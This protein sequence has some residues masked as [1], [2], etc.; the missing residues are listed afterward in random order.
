MRS[1]I[2]Y[3]IKFP[4][5]V[6]IM[7]LSII[8]FGVFGFLGMKSSYFPLNDSKTIRIAI[9]YLGASPQ[10]IEE[11]IVLKIEDNLKGLVGIDRVT[12]IS[13]ENSGVITVEIEK[14]QDIDIML[15][16]VKNAVDR[17]P[18]FPT[19][20]EPVVVNKI[21]S[22][23]ETIS[24]T[25]SG[26]NISLKA[27]KDI[28]RNIENELRSMDGISQINITGYPDEEIEIAVREKDLLAYNLTFG[29]VARA[30]SRENILATGGNIKTDIEEYLIR[31]NSKSY[32]AKELDYIIVRADQN[33]NVIRLKD[34]A[35]VK[36]R[37]AESPNATF[38]NGELAVNI[39]ISN[40]NDED[41]LS[42]ASTIKSFISD[43]N[44]R[45]NNI[46]LNVVSDQSIPLNQRTQL[47]AENAMIGIVL[48]LFFLSLFLNTRLAF[49]VAAG[50]PIAFF[51]MFIFASSLGV[52]INILSL[53]GMIIV[54]GILV[55]DG[56]VIAENIYHHY[57]KGKSR[58]QAAIDGTMEVI[59][60]IVSAI[61]TT[62]LAFSTFL[63]LDGRIGDFFGEVSVVVI[64]T[65]SISLI[66]V[67]IIL[68]AHMAHSKALGIHDPNEEKKGLDKVFS[69]LRSFNKIGD[70]IISFLRDKLYSKVLHFTLE[71]KFLS[72]AIWLV[73]L[74]L[75]IGSIGGGIIRTTF[76]PTVA[77]DRVSIGLKMPEGTTIAVTDSILSLIEA[78]T[79]LINNDFTS[80]QTENRKVV[81]N[82]IKNLGPGTANGSLDVNLLPGELRDAPSA[83]IANAIRAAVGPV[84]G[85]E[86]LTFGSGGNFGGR[87]ISVSL[88]GNNIKELKA[89]KEELKANMLNNAL[90]ADITDNDPKGIKEIKINLKE[91][92]YLIGL[93][94]QE[95]MNQ[96][97]YAFFGFQAQR[98]QR[99][100]DEIR[101]WVRFDEENRSSINKLDEMR[102]ATPD[103]SRVPFAEIAEYT[104]E[105]GEVSINHLDGRREIQVSADL[106]DPSESATDILANI[107]NNVVPEI[108]SK[109]PTVGALFEGQNREAN[110]LAQSAK[111]VIPIIIFLIY[112]T[113]AFTFRS[114]GQPFL[115][116]LLIPFSLI[117]VAWGHYIHQFPI[118]LL[119]WLGIIALIGIMVNDGLVLIVKF[120]SYLK[121]GMDYDAALYRAAK[122]RFRAIF[123][124]S[125]TTMAG[126]A[127]LILETSRQ[128][129]YL[130]P[131][132][133][134]VAYGIAIATVLT[135]LVLPLFLSI[136]N[137]FK[138][139]LKW[140]LTGERVP[141]ENVERAVKELMSDSHV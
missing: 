3:F 113:I 60:P 134:S 116:L 106:S 18:S 79:W 27:L 42:S 69:K 9:T 130:I 80:R 97:R 78:K 126:L 46:H 32:V 35:D 49:W 93:S 131:M 45:Y 50:L 36:D 107:K 104:I 89:A 53:F 90:L 102:I 96:V 110:K 67:L 141:K 51:G 82:I 117:G 111:S 29:E 43:F 44:Q 77:S 1:I 108:L 22:V 5:S 39:S 119:S 121:E 124:T 31:A 8:L 7:M 6:N 115:L 133:I 56:I 28:A 109:Y 125:L 38:Y 140:L 48:V 65:L 86:S 87:P 41:L 95:V 70:A 72:L 101:V 16:E 68:P 74:I 57:E 122:S 52:T 64:L 20:M 118:N 17:V 75:T 47:L 94:T 34:I 137:N 138:V 13:S 14:G 135:L 33:G 85:I 83:D 132:A 136:S 59:P 62:L 105:R 103:G 99:G 15:T 11:G 54:I 58:I 30:V 71:N 128:A 92:A 88:L 4:V 123:L 81:Q 55:D 19:G 73:F 139:N 100:Q 61:I 12:S 40:T 25:L 129:Q 21:E 91:N 114:Y 63:F 66:E 76:F 26:E 112:V 23:R 2:T 24:F 84:Y 10:E 127:P 37:F 120:N 98:F